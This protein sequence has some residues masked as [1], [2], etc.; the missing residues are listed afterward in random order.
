MTSI[1]EAVR[2][3]AHETSWPE[4]D[5]WYRA[6][7]LREAGL[8]KAGRAGRGGV[9]AVSITT[10]GIVR[11]ILSTCS[12]GSKQAPE[13]VRRF[14]TLVRSD[15]HG[16]EPRPKLVNDL[17]SLIEEKRAGQAPLASFPVRLLLIFDQ[18]APRAEIRMRSRSLQD[19]P[20]DDVLYVVGGWRPASQHPNVT[21]H[22]ATVIGE[23]IFYILAR[24]V[25]PIKRPKKGR[26]P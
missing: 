11:L 10:K 7:W 20:D 5:L 12:P 23:E 18:D 15:W 13:T 4:T 6:R 22:R 26:S 1:A 3:L 17:V 25:G 24:I 14:E 16:S 9:G 21:F 2:Q 19:L 8:L